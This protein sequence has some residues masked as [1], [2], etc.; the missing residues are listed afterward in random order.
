[1]NDQ[2]ANLLFGLSTSALVLIAAAAALVVLVLAV[3]APW[4]LYR[5][6]CNLMRLVAAQEEANKLARAS[7]PAVQ[8][9][10]R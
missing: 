1:M 8:V 2:A 10:H 4:F 7:R 3:M 5:I 6:H 9:V